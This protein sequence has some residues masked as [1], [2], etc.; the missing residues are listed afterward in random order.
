MTIICFVRPLHPTNMAIWIINWWE[1][2]D[3]IPIKCYRNARNIFNAK[4]IVIDLFQLGGGMGGKRHE[5]GAINYNK[6]RKVENNN[7]SIGLKQNIESN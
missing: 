7:L 4:C 2:K 6:K 1:F 3:D 5:L